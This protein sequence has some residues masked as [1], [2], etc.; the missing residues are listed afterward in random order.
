MKTSMKQRLL[1]NRRTNAGFLKLCKLNE[2]W[3]KS[4]CMLPD[5][6]YSTSRQWRGARREDTVDVRDWLACCLYKI[7]HVEETNEF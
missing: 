3:E 6:L 2:R 5:Q 4:I 7:C 1:Q